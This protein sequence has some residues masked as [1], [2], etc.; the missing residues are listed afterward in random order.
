MIPDCIY[1][2]RRSGKT[3][4]ALKLCKKLGA[5]LVVDNFKMADWIKEN[6]QYDEKIK[7]YTFRQLLNGDLNGNKKPFIIDEI[8]FLVSMLSG[9]NVVA[10]TCTKPFTKKDRKKYNL[11][12]SI[13][14]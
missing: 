3:T 6:P 7:I 12:E 9:G 2:K 10:F 8:Q 13:K 14:Y 11:P 1:G 5:D 4:K